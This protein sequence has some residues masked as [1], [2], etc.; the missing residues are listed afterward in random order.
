M[1]PS[2]LLLS[3]RSFQLK[4][5]GL[6]T[7]A[8]V[9]CGVVSKLALDARTVPA[10]AYFTASQFAVTSCPF[11]TIGGSCNLNRS[12]RDVPKS[13]GIERVEAVPSPSF[14]SSVLDYFG[15]NHLR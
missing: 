9:L 3:R 12:Q 10:F 7:P 6:P 2:F 14:G 15:P 13:F 11:H 1:W 8:N 4:I 5:S